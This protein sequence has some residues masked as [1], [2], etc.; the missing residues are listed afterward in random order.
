MMGR[1][2]LHPVALFHV[3][4]AQFAPGGERVAF[5]PD[6]ASEDVSR[7]LQVA[8]GLVV[9]HERV[10][11]ARVGVLQVVGLAVVLDRVVVPLLG[12]HDFAQLQ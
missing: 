8:L 3:Q 9:F 1:Q 6:D 11:R 4:P 2:S 10:K 12:A 7:V 5:Q